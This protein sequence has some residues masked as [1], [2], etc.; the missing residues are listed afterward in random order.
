MSD[1][2]CAIKCVRF[3]YPVCV[4][5]FVGSIFDWLCHVIY[6]LFLERVSNLCS[7]DLFCENLCAISQNLSFHVSVCTA[8][9]GR[10]HIPHTSFFLKS[11]SPSP[12]LF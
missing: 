8:L 12:R 6:V 4:L 9:D 11:S 5:L 10:R 1:I 3:V 2:M 7:V